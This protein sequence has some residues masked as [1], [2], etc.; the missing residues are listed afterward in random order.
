MGRRPRA[1]RD[2]VDVFFAL[3]AKL[4][5]D[6][7]ALF[8]AFEAGDEVFW[9][10]RFKKAETRSP[11]S[12]P[13]AFVGLAG[14]LSSAQTMFGSVVRCSGVATVFGL[15]FGFDGSAPR[16]SCVV[17]EAAADATD[18]MVTS[19][20]RSSLF[21]PAGRSFA[22]WSIGDSDG[23]PGSL[24]GSLDIARGRMGGIEKRF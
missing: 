22:D 23:S 7:V 21:G 15:G 1:V 18:L 9:R 10:W 4:D 2:G 11:M 19:R 17:W 5:G 13:V 6:E 24:D 14:S 16:S 20:S 12:L 3:G 8:A